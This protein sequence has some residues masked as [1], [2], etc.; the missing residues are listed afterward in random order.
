MTLAYGTSIIAMVAYT[1]WLY[2]MGS[3]RELL[4]PLFVSLLL[5][6]CLL[7]HVGQGTQPALPRLVLLISTYVVVLSAVNANVET[8]SL[9]WGLPIAATFC[10]F[11]YGVRWRSTRRA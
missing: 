9:W 2:A 10:C 11:L 4:V 7:M 8:S 1:L 3:Y 6:A 5:L